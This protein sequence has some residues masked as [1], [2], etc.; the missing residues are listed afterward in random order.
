M[1]VE[2]ISSSGSRIFSSTDPELNNTFAITRAS[3]RCGGVGCETSGPT[4]TPIECLSECHNC[5]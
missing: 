5:C 3:H 1:F 2:N 4:P